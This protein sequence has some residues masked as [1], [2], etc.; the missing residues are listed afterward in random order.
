MPSQNLRDKIDAEFALREAKREQR[1]GGSGITEEMY[2]ELEAQAQ[3]AAS[4]SRSLTDLSTLPHT[5]IG[6][7][8]SAT[9]IP[10]DIA[11]PIYESYLTPEHEDEYL[12]T[13]DATFEGTTPQLESHPIR[14]NEKE[15]EIALRN[16]VSVYNWLRRNEPHVFLQD[17]NPQS[18]APVQKSKEALKEASKHLKRA[19][20]VAKQEPKHDP[21]AIDED[22]F[23]AG[24]VMEAPTKAKRKR[25]DEPYRPKG[26]SSRPYK[27]KKVGG[28]VAE[29]RLED[30]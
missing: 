10:G 7:A 22:G 18:D 9:E 11:D 27:K 5:M 2:L 29:R 1:A 30:A 3:A 12:A 4:R 24:G 19:S 16:P 13:L 6:G 21:E 20:I 8:I 25:D 28:G 26:G 17:G 14:S 15:R 23:V